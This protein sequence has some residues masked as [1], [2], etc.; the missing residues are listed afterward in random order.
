YPHRQR[1]RGETEEDHQQVNRAL[2]EADIYHLKERPV[3]RL[4]GGEHRR[5]L[6]ARALAQQT[7]LLLLDEPTAHLDVTHQVE[8]LVL[9]QRL[10][11]QE[12]QVGVLAALHDLN[13]A[14]E[15]CDRLVLLSAGRIL[16]DGPPEAVLTA[17]NLRAA[18][19]ADAQIG[20]NPATGRP[21]ILTLHPAR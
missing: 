5:V 12:Q 3:T 6:L 9:A 14:A 4:S 13:Q 8:L 21:T 19:G 16:A 11:R 7:P 15:F 20:R 17:G 2:A 10:T 1:F 18:Y